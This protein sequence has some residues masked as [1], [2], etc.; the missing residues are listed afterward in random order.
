M[1]STMSSLCSMIPQSVP[2]S[3]PASPSPA[4]AMTAGTA[5]NITAPDVHGPSVLFKAT[6]APYQAPDFDPWNISL[7]DTV[8]SDTSL[9]WLNPDAVGNKSLLKL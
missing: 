4:G 6:S 2:P 1:P 8:S 7:S 3:G 9:R 5:C